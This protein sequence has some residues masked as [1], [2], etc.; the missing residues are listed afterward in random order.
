MKLK[1]NFVCSMTVFVRINNGKEKG[2][3]HFK[4]YV[5]KYQSFIPM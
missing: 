3:I 5:F 2:K 4:L 1:W